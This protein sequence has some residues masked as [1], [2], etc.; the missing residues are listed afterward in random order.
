MRRVLKD[1][2]VACSCLGS[3]W[4]G[5]KGARFATNKPRDA[6]MGRGKDGGDMEEAVVVV[7]V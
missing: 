7:F 6:M 4:L 1:L 3:S 2:R 5:R